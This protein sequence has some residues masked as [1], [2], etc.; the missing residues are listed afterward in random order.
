MTTSNEVRALLRKRYQHPEWALMFEVANGTGIEGKS[1]A[2]A[3]AMNLYPSRGLAIHGFE[4]KVS[5]QDFMR[6]IEKP[7]KSVPVQQFCDHWWL[8]AP[9]KAVDESLL[10]KAWGWL[11]VDGDRLVQAK[12]APDLEAKPLSR[13]FIAAMVRRQN[14]AD[15]AEVDK[16]V[17][18]RV[19]ALREDER[20]RTEREIEMRTREAQSAI[21]KLADLKKRI[22]NDRWDSLNA[23]E[24]AQAVKIVRKAGVLGTYDGIESVRNTIK[25]ALRSIDEAMMPFDAEKIVTK[26][27]AE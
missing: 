7:D 5:K 19:D 9:A 6:E 26:E 18:V 3:V 13:A 1:Y 23:D 20:K 12:A 15:A 24:I 10:P 2:D 8:V 25:A 11:R 21:D 22:G 16:L 14:A 27:A 17:R 4:I